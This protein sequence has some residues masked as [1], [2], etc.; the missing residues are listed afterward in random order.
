MN[1]E[2]RIAS[3]SES[4]AGLQTLLNEQTTAARRTTCRLLAAVYEL[5]IYATAPGREDELVKALNARDLF[6]PKPGE[7]IWGKIIPMSCGDWE[8]DHTGTVVVGSGGKQKWLKNASL[9]KYAR[10]L[11]YMADDGVPPAEA[12]EFMLGYPGLLDGIIEADKRRYPASKRGIG[13]EKMAAANRAA[14]EL[15]LGWIEIGE[16]HN[17]EREFMCAYGVLQDGQFAL[18]GL[19]PESQRKAQTLAARKG[20]GLSSC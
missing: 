6:A 3:I 10:V 15:V 14:D 13:P 2:E 11:R 20:E 5:G 8:R 19:I 16:Q 1:I 7:N 4:N 9:D 12:A 18:I 17:A